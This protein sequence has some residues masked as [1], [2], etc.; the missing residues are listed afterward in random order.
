MSKYVV[1]DYNGNIREV[2]AAQVRDTE[3]FV[4][5]YSG[6]GYLVLRMRQEHVAMVEIAP[7]GK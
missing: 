3:R 1:T 4:D 7:E 6:G 2:E 5:F